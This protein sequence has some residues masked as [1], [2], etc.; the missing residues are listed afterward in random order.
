[1]KHMAEGNTDLP[2]GIQII[3]VVLIATRF[4]CVTAALSRKIWV[5]IFMIIL[6]VI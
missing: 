4:K 2:N 5:S 1:M 6:A 3:I